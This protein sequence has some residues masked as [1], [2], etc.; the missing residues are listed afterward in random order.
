[1]AT[2]TRRK[3]SPSYLRVAESYAGWEWKTP[4]VIEFTM[5]DAYLARPNLYPRQATLLKIVFLQDDLFTDYDYEVIAEWT[6]SYLDSMGD[7]GEGNNGIVPDVLERIRICKEQGRPW[8]RENVVVIG[9]RGS[10]GHLG[11][12]CGCYVLWNYMGYGDPHAHY[13]V[14]RDKQ[15]ACQV[16]AAKKDQARAHQW[17]DLNNFIIGAPCFSPYISRALGETLS[18]FAPHDF[19]RLLERE[20]RGVYSERDPATFLIEARESTVTAARGP[21]SFM[22]FYDE[23]AHVVRQVAKND[24]GEV[25]DSAT[26]ALDQFKADAFMWE[27]S[28]PWQRIGRFYENYQEVLQHNEDGAPIYPE[29]L[30]VQLTSWDIYKDWERTRDP[31]LMLARP[32]TLYF[33]PIPFEPLTQ[34][35]QEYDA[36]M[37]QLEKANPE[38]FRV[39]RR[40]HFASVL[41]AYLTEEKVASLW[42]PWPAES[43]VNVNLSV[44]PKTAHSAN[45]G[46]LSVAYRAHGDPSKSG[47]NFGFAIAHI[48]SFDERGLPH[49]VFDVIHAWLPEDFEGHEVD[50]EFIGNDLKGYL[51]RFMPVEL[52]FDQFNS[53]NT[54]QQLRKHVR[55]RRY[56]KQVTI[57]ERTANGPLNWKTYET[58]KTALGLGLLHGPYFELADLELKFLQDVGHQKVDHPTAGP[59]QTKDVA[60]CLAICTYELIGEQIAAFVGK[61]LNEVPLGVGQQGGVVP[62]GNQ[63][64]ETSV[65]EGFSQFSRRRRAGG[66][67][68][69]TRPRGPRSRG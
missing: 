28:S 1:M 38:T 4:D 22:Q 67:M 10:K 29:K 35:I 7:S 44:D 48:H 25:Y 42:E 64:S 23:M 27:P 24:A 6:R 65:Q 9:R 12:I 19:I 43:P 15:L 49:V 13:G 50:Y 2:R 5:S 11:A 26:P 3:T 14:D 46:I 56:P 8:F 41:D 60:D 54:I 30:M 33:D 36:N 55:E 34:A 59:V 63:M 66:G 40:S 68:P 31:A 53:V 61:M 16:F 62:F 47:A 20:S 17:G 52:T 32:E 21:A 51:D 57:Y 39:E 18:V 58:F 45:R 69:P 37:Q